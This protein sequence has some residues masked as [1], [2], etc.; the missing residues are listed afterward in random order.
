MI[1]F[2]AAAA[3]SALLA[4]ACE[5]RAAGR[6]RAF[7]LLKPLT[8]LLIL[9]AA[10]TA[11]DAGAAYRNW[12]GLA[13]LLSLCGD[14]A[15]MFAGN[16]AFMAGLGSFLLAHGV[17]VWA[18]LA[19][20]EF[21]PPVWSAIAVFVATGF[22]WWLLPRTGSLRVPV[23][24]YALALVGMTLAAASRA[25]LRADPSGTLAVIGA[26]VFLLSDG[27]LA[28]RQFQGPYP[29]AQPLILLSYWLAI[30]L[31]ATSVARSAPLV[32]TVTGPQHEVPSPASD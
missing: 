31:I 23:L 6:H 16:A 32:P 15:L 9:A 29:R 3:V 27:A 7:Y 19:G 26:L 2:L 30:G 22:L 13:L 17:F 12:V 4:V 11:D 5:E 1:A 21:S 24:L 25:E 8:T 10:A 18:F 20:G 28:V 14:I